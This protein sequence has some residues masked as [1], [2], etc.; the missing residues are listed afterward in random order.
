MSW[1]VDSCILSSQILYKLVCC[2]NDIV[3]SFYGGIKHILL[4]LLQITL[5][6]I[7]LFFFKGILV[8]RFTVHMWCARVNIFQLFICILCLSVAIMTVSIFIVLDFEGEVCCFVL[9][10]LFNS[11]YTHVL[12]LLALVSVFVFTLLLFSYL[13][14]GCVSVNC[15][16][17]SCKMHFIFRSGYFFLYMELST[18]SLQVSVNCEGILYLKDSSLLVCFL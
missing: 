9:D 7:L 8:G 10:L 6:A 2:G 15:H 12:S 3:E 18:N 5:L 4:L 16:H 14:F 1:N 11:L 17:I 13:F